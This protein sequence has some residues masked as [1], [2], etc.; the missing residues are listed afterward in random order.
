MW[1]AR[2]WCEGD[3]KGIHI[4]IIHN[5]HYEF[6]SFCSLCFRRCWMEMLWFGCIGCLLTVLL[7]EADI[8]L[9]GLFGPRFVEGFLDFV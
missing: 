4:L 5:T 1:Y 6:K 3:K 2:A 8:S 9:I 7:V